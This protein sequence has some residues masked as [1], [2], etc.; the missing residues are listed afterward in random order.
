[1]PMNIDESDSDSAAPGSPRKLQRRGTPLVPEAPALGSQAG[2][3][4]ASA[5]SVGEATGSVEDQI[6][7]VLE[8]MLPAVLEQ[9]LTRSLDRV[10]ETRLASAFDRVIEDK[11]VPRIENVCAEKFVWL[12][13]SISLNP[14]TVAIADLNKQVIELM[15]Y[16]RGEVCRA[17]DF[18]N[19]RCSARIR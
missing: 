19:R 17:T 12:R 16:I 13:F 1:M 5:E 9:S 10:L 3:A 18:V 6:S 14:N 15:K 7:R 8:R 11:I 4:S 2:V